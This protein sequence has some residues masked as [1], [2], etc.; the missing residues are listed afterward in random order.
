MHNRFIVVVLAKI[1]NSSPTILVKLIRKAWRGKQEF[2]SNPEIQNEPKMI[3]NQ[4]DK[5]SD[6][7]TERGTDSG[8]TNRETDRHTGRR[9]DGILMEE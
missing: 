7:Q 6:R 2:S 1:V 5:H 4:A 3:E 9:T 8:R